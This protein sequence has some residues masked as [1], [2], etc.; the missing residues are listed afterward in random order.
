MQKRIMVWWA[1]TLIAWCSSEAWAT[2]THQG[3][4]G[5][6]VL[7]KQ[8]KHPNPSNAFPRKTTSDVVRRLRLAQ[9]QD[10]ANQSKEDEIPGGRWPV[11]AWV[12]E[13]VGAAVV[14]GGAVCFALSAGRMTDRDQKIKEANADIKNNGFSDVSA[15]AVKKAEDEAIA[16]NTAGW[17][18]TGVGV[19]LVLVGAIWMFV[20]RPPQAKYVRRDLPKIPN[21]PTLANQPSRFAQGTAP[22]ALLFRSQIP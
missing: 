5:R 7:T 13:G 9:N 20:H 3:T 16:L 19:A 10:N 11:G 15:A 6:T 2:P 18:V 14:V 1:L 17:V 21:V 8:A 4:T 22:P 12:L